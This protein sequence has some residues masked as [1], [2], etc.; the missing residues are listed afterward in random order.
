[1]FTRKHLLVVYLISILFILVLTGCGGAPSAGSPDSAKAAPGAFKVAILLPGEPNDKAWS[2]TGYEGLKLIEKELGAQ[3]AHTPNVSE[4]DAEK[5]ARQYAT[6]G[7][8]FIIGHGGEYI[9]AF[10][11]VAEEFPRVKFAVMAGYA[12]NNKNFGALSFRDS[13]LG[14]LAGVVAGLKTKT[15][16]VAFIGGV[17][18]PHMQEQAASFERGAKAVNPKVE[19]ATEWVGSWTDEAKSKEIA[20]AQVKA[21]ADVL[22]G[23]VDAASRI[24]FETAKNAGVYALG[25]SL[26]QHDLAPDTILTSGIQRM[27]VLAL[28]GATLVQ[29][30]R[31]EGKQYKFGLQEGA[32]D[33]APFYGLLSS[34]EETRVKTVREDIMTGKVDV[35][36]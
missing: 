30:G 10:E 11:A 9:P 17:D 1:M 16:K 8:E 4:A 12:G 35:T 23:S 34:E 5:V 31:W 32:Q 25:W 36:Q 13:E 20:E 29:Q 26:D 3:V 27:P 19:V 7:Y 14:Y 33:L 2:Q 22:L 21:G 24:V 6:D 18:Y 15:N 28:E